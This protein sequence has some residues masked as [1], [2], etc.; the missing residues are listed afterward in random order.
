EADAQ[1]V[2]DAVELVDTPLA[3]LPPEFDEPLF[4]ALPNLEE[5]LD[6][7]LPLR[8]VRPPLRR[9]VEPLP[10]PDA[11]RRVLDRHHRRRVAHVRRP[12]GRRRRLLRAMLLDVGQLFLQ[13]RA[14]V[15]EQMGDAVWLEELA[16]VDLPLVGD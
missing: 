5:L 8:H 4:L 6:L 11:L 16:R 2:V 3:R 15:L 12:R 10:A 1:L 14:D 7:L 9:R 13:L